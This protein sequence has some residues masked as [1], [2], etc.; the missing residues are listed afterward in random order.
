MSDE[1]R[2]IHEKWPRLG[3]VGTIKTLEFCVAECESLAAQ[4]KELA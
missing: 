2:K 1:Y 3:E 4:L